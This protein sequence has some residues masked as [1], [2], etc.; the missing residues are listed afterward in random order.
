MVQGIGFGVTDYYAEST[1]REFTCIDIAVDS[2]K[3]GP[4][5]IRLFLD[6]DKKAEMLTELA[7]QIAKQVLEHV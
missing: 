2:S 3:H 1:S 7:D 4:T 5:N 6:A